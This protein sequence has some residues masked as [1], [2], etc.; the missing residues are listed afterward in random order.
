VDG[1]VARFDSDVVSADNGVIPNT[2]SRIPCGQ[3]SKDIAA[4]EAPLTSHAILSSKPASDCE[5]LMTNSM[6][7]IGKGFL[8]C[9]VVNTFCTFL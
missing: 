7:N 6:Q 3:L 1:Y 8:I 2:L 4:S 9:F 5:H